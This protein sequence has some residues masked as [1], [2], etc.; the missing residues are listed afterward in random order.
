M[1]QEASLTFMAHTFL[2]EVAMA[3]C[4]ITIWSGSIVVPQSV[5]TLTFRMWGKVHVVF[6]PAQFKLVP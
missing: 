6:I 4:W 5:R 3:M 2:L 1:A